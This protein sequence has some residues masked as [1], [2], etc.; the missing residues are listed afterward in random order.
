MIFGLKTN[1][2]ATLHGFPFHLFFSFH[3]ARIYGQCC[4]CISILCQFI[5]LPGSNLKNFVLVH[6]QGCQSFLGPNI[7]K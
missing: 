7:P 1:H 4:F 6:N 3:F 5:F 2:L